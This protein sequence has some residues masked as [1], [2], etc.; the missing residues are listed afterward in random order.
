MPAISEGPDGVK[1]KA[2]KRRWPVT[3]GLSGGTNT[4]EGRTTN[5]VPRK[6]L[7]S[8]REKKGL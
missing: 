5:L 2:V 4:Q 3:K 7:V 8:E 6:S 1:Q